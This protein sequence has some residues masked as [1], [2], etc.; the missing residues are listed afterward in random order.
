MFFKRIFGFFLFLFFFNASLVDVEGNVQPDMYT[1]DD[2]ERKA[3]LTRLIAEFVSWPYDLIG[4]NNSFIVAVY[5]DE[6]FY[7]NLLLYYKDVEFKGVKPNILLITD[8]DEISD[9]HI[10]FLTEK[11]NEYINQILKL[12]T[13]R[14]ILT[15]GDYKDFGVKGTIINFYQ[16]EVK[17]EINFNSYQNSDLK[18]DSRLFDAAKIID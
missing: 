2:T 9:S 4:D 5:N 17:F 16:D 13:N 11:S 14:P 1:F 18:I 12:T 15:I 6:D 3:Y 10:L 7:E 8:L